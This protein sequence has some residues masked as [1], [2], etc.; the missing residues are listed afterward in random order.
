MW[1][2]RGWGL[3]GRVY[4]HACVCLYTH[5]A[6][7]ASHSVET[8]AG[9]H[10]FARLSLDPRESYGYYFGYLCDLGATIDTELQ[11]W[12]WNTPGGVP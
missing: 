7:D 8:Q 5:G 11:I 9:T 12:A 10:V 2:W 6:R 1:I 4:V 3:Y